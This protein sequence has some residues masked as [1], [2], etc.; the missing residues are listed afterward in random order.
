[1]PQRDPR[2][3][4]RTLFRGTFDL[5]LILYLKDAIISFRAAIYAAV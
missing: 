4:V 1:M 3:A 2:P 5:L